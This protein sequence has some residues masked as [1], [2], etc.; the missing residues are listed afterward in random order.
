[1]TGKKPKLRSDLILSPIEGS[2]SP[3]FVL[4]DPITD[5]FFTFSEYEQYLLTLLDGRNDLEAV[6]RA[7][8]ERFSATLSAETLGGFLGRIESLGFLEG[9]AEAREAAVRQK[10]ALRGEHGPV[11]KILHVR[12]RAFN[13]E[14]VLARL[15]EPARFF[16]TRSF[17][18]VAVFTILAAV[19]VTVANWPEMTRAFGRVWNLNGFL[20]FWFSVLWVVALHEFAHALTCR[21][22]GGR[23]TEMGFLLIYFQPAFYSDVSDAWLFPEKRKR[24]W[25]MFS[26]G[27][28]QLFLWSAAAILWRLTDPDVFM[29]NLL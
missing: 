8:E 23:V 9:E 24:L 19:C 12:V 14:K 20:I 11:E 22:F 21:H 7:F 27:F 2:P 5:N 6:R 29:N 18:L 25:V 10:E 4:K 1:M 3:A 13:P 16:F 15:L 28:F 26:G 17:V